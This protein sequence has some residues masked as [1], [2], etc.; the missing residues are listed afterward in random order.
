MKELNN[1]CLLICSTRFTALHQVETKAEKEVL[2][3]QA[4]R[5]DHISLYVDYL[6]VKKPDS[7]LAVS[8]LACDSI[9]F[10]RL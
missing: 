10:F 2:L 9:R 8:R 5:K 4:K 7:R 1:G 3:S 6:L